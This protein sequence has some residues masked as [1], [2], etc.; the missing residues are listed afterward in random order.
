MNQRRQGLRKPAAMLG[1]A[2]MAVLLNT[3]VGA[4]RAAAMGQIAWTGSAVVITATTAEDGNLDYWWQQ[5]GTS[6][7]HPQVVA[8]GRQYATPAIA[9]TGSAVVITA[10]DQYGN[11]DYWW[12]Q[13]GTSTWHQETVGDIRE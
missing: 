7:W 2:L 11:L 6:T 9:W 4:D 10:T 8:I 13:A 5:A 3:L 12:Q 1:F